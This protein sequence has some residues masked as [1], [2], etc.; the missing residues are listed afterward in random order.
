MRTCSSHGNRLESCSWRKGLGSCI[1]AVVPLLDFTISQQG[2]HLILL[3]S[4]TFCGLL[5]SPWREEWTL[6]IQVT[7]HS[8]SWNPQGLC[9]RK[10][11]RGSIQKQ[12]EEE[13]LD[14][15]LELF[16]VA[17][18]NGLL[19]HLYSCAFISGWAVKEIEGT[20]WLW[21]FHVASIETHAISFVF[22]L[23]LLTLYSVPTCALVLFSLCSRRAG[24]PV[25]ETNSDQFNRS[26]RGV[27]CG[28]RKASAGWGQCDKDA[29]LGQHGQEGPLW[30]GVHL[31]RD[32]NGVKVKMTGLC[33]GGVVQAEVT[34]CV[35]VLKAPLDA[36][37]SVTYWTWVTL[38]FWCFAWKYTQELIS[39]D[40]RW[41]KIMMHDTSTQA[42]T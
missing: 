29:L 25:G 33:Q 1:T 12:R 32:L 15:Y 9:R 17:R 11:E 38:K 7:L 14:F 35:G 13:N 23:H 18:E 5:T 31:S 10:A 41:K 28:M 4:G 40:F 26:I 21:S 39:Y 37:I 20:A 30:G 6:A 2:L 22:C 34:A 36:G 3:S 19:T 16:L 27:V 42:P 24:I 8:P